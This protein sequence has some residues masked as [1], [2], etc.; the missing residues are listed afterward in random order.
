MRCLLSK[1]K[2]VHKIF[3]KSTCLCTVSIT[4][5]K[6]IWG[7]GQLK[8]VERNHTRYKQGQLLGYNY[9]PINDFR[10]ERSLKESKT[11]YGKRQPPRVDPM[12]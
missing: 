10:Y 11:Y 6:C 2:I 12:G 3:S 9:V 8:T 1:K 4:S 7:V 5:L